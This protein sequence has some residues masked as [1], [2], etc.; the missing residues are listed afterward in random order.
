MKKLINARYLVLV[1]LLLLLAGCPPFPVTILSPN[2]GAHFEVGEEI[3]FTG[4]AKDFQ[5]GELTGD[6]LVWTSDQDGQIGTG[7]FF[8]RD[9]LSEGK[10]KIM[11]TATNSQEEERTA[12]ITITIS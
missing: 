12:T 5:D 10:H 4:S 7:T 8:T 11:L 9:D 2:N 6:S 3:T 1:L